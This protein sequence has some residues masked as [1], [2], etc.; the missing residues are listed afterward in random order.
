[1]TDPDP[2]FLEWLKNSCTA[3]GVPLKLEDPKVLRRVAALLR[4]AETTVPKR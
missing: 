4:I 2:A 3:S 1:M